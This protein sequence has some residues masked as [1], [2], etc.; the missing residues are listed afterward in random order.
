[1][2]LI[3]FAVADVINPDWSPAE[4]M[5]SHYVHAPYGGWLVC[6]AR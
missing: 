6:S 5:I 4:A 1:M 2:P 3:G